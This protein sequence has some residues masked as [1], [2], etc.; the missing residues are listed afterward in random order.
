[1]K[2]LVAFASKHGSTA[3]VA[4]SIA[5]QLRMEDL[6]VDQRD[7][8]DV[9]SIEGYDGV[10]LGSAV[11][12]GKL[13][14]EARA[15]VEAHRAQLNN[16]PVWLFSSGPIGA[17]DPKPHAEAADVE[18]LVQAI[19][20]RDHKVFAGKLD[21]RELGLGERLVAKLAG[22]QGGDFRNRDAI[23]SWA[24]DIAHELIAQRV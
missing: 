24:H 15:F 21:K 10:I 3:G 4:Q 19:H 13:L 5:V 20:A 23:E 7:A 12:M 11:Y 14:P 17:P 16:I 18:A 1:M 9:T 6:D 2:V 22:A 8:K